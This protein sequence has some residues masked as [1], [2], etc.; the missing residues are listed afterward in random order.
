VPSPN[1]RIAAAALAATALGGAALAASPAMAI[2]GGAPA[3]PAFWPFIAAIERPGDN[4][5]LNQFCAGTMV[6]PNLVLTAAHCVFQEERRVLAREVQ[7]RPGGQPLAKSRTP[8]IRVGRIVVHPRYRPG[9]RGWDA[10]LLILTAPSPAPAIRVAL[11]AD[12]A[13]T[14]PG[15]AALVAG[16]GDLTD[17]NRRF[18]TTLRS[19]AV[20]LVEPGRCEG[21]LGPLFSA[22]SD[23]CA[24]VM[25]KGGPDTCRGDSGGPLI[26]AGLTGEPLLA[27]ITSSGYGCGRTRSP[28]VYTRVSALS[29][30]LGANGVNTTP[31]APVPPPVPAPAAPG[32][33]VA[34]PA[35]PA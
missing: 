2:R 1:R 28:G 13:A 7:V 29:A 12:A 14:E 9:G 8:R 19:G 34:P 30:W 22:S 25:R 26:V 33:G 32:P 23:L 11:P 5:F 21:L 6:A 16:W 20:P 4:D 24:G 27:G 10:A 35:P 15:D 31:P 18:P 3:D 17:G